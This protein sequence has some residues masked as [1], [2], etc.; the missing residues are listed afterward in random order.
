MTNRQT[1]Y[2]SIDKPWLKYYPR[3]AYELSLPQQTLYQH[4]WD[5]NRTHPDDIAL[6]YY[7]S[8]NAYKTLFQNIKRAADA[9]YSM[10]IRKGDIVTIMA[11]QTPECIYLLYG[12]NY[13]GAVA[14]MVYMTLSGDEII[15]SVNSTSSK[16]L[17]ILD[18][19]LNQIESLKDK[20]KVP[21]V[22]L[23]V[24]DSMPA[25]MRIGYNL[26]E[27]KRHSFLSYK[28]FISKADQPACLSEDYEAA[29]VIVY[30]SGTTGNPKG[31]V[32][33]NNS[34][35]ALVHQ[36]L[37]GLV[38]FVRGKTCLLILPPFVGFGV[39][40]I[41][42][43]LTAGVVSILQINLDPTD[44]FKTLFKYNPFCFISGPALIEPLLNYSKGNLDQLK[45]F[46]GGGGAVTTR[47]EIA[48]NRY[49]N[50]CGSP[51]FYANGY[52]MTEASSILS[53]NLWGMKKQG[54]LG[55]PLLLT[56]V[57]VVD[58]NSNEELPYGQVGELL[59]STPALMKGY[60]NDEKAT[61]EIF[62]RD[63][64]GKTWLRTGD[65]GYIDEDGFIFLEG[66]IKRIFITMGKD[67]NAYKL[68]P[69]RIEDAIL[70]EFNEVETCAVIVKADELKMNVAYA[71]VTLKNRAENDRVI[72]NEINHRL[73]EKLPEFMMPK[74]IIIVDS[75]PVT[76]TGKIDYQKLG[77]TITL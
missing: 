69:Q 14:N 45:Y 6:I 21:I 56:N 38:D 17:L 43:L 51:A 32:L 10:G 66:R 48:V 37:N 57:K 35:N 1:G 61:N 40:H 76:P 65:L 49:L 73:A 34:I 22:V 47:Q 67:N 62:V 2:P 52:G 12:L 36:D 28:A 19:V 33:S 63:S 75:I 41:Q 8:K 74:D 23:S 55:F 9:F 20:I 3:E 64:D 4:M 11:M 70:D 68:F 30:T 7:G 16:M 46:F 60:F 27:K 31:V 18:P 29:A 42:I 15:A 26:K 59:F 54:S 39:A 77:E 24:S 58:T 53:I 71:V 13:I 25:Y 44:I 72:V 50:E 5:N